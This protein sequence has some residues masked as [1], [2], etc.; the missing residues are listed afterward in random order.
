VLKFTPFVVVGV[1]LPELESTV[2]QTG[3]VVVSIE[4][5]A[6]AVEQ[7]VTPAF[8]ATPAPLM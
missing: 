5:K 2:S 8:A 1:R 6:A 3:R 7:K 4:K